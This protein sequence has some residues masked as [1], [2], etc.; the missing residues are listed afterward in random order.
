ML[1]LLQPWAAQAQSG[2]Y[3]LQPINPPFLSSWTSCGAQYIGD[4][5]D[6]VGRCGTAAGFAF[7]SGFPV[8]FTQYR[9]IVWRSGRSSPV[10][11]PLPSGQSAFQIHGI[12]AKGRVAATLEPTRGGSGSTGLTMVTWDGNQRSNWVTSYPY[13]NWYLSHGLTA[14]GQLAVAPQSPGGGDVRIVVAGPTSGRDVP[15]PPNVAAG[16]GKVE[17]RSAG[18]G[19]ML[20]VNDSGQIALVTTDRN[21]DFSGPSRINPRA[22]FW[23]GQAWREILPPDGGAWLPSHNLRVRSLNN[24]GQVL[25]SEYSFENQ[26]TRDRRY[27][28]REDQGL[29]K[30]PDDVH[31]YSAEG[32]HT[33]ADNGD[34]FGQAQFEGVQDLPRIGRYRAAVWRNGQMIDLNTLVKPPAGYAFVDVADVN[35]KGQML[36][37]MDA[38]SVTTSTS[39]LRPAVLWPR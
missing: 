10:S 28:W 14:E 23:N 25:L 24:A 20:W 11:L 34:V 39:R 38:L 16:N 5:G 33:V 7:Q 8:I 37:Y 36:V 2:G 29:R 22:W 9:P 6:V 35:A 12:D 27:L 32:L 18:G 3:T 4:N 17:M 19:G 31:I 15:A 1:M 21:P 13:L 30:L 26:T